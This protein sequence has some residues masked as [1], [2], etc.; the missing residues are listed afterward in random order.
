MFP[1]DIWANI[2]TFVSLQELSL[3]QRVSWL[4]RS[5]VEVELGLRAELGLSSGKAFVYWRVA[6]PLSIKKCLWPENV[7]RNLCMAFRYLQKPKEWLRFGRPGVYDVGWPGYGGSGYWGT[8]RPADMQSLY[9]SFPDPVVEGYTSFCVYKK[10]YN[11]SIF[12]P[13]SP[14]FSETVPLSLNQLS[15]CGVFCIET[16]KIEGMIKMDNRWADRAWRREFPLQP[17][18]RFDFDFF[19]TGWRKCPRCQ[20]E[21][22]AY[23]WEITAH[24]KSGRWPYDEE[25]FERAERYVEAQG[26]IR[27]RSGCGCWDPDDREMGIGIREYLSMHSNTDRIQFIGS[28]QSGDLI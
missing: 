9:L 25:Q 6:Q 23:S 14:D 2:L 24:P 21:N 5:A 26:V 3:L 17:L 10:D 22:L 28:P 20:H 27:G 11:K 13:V 18:K 19:L 8:R 16:E 15:L 1:F 4:L 7:K 12:P